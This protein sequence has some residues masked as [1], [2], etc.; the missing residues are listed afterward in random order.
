MSLSQRIAPH[1]LLC[2][3]LVRVL[4]STDHSAIVECVVPEY[5]T[6]LVQRVRTRTPHGALY[7]THSAT[8]NA[9]RIIRYDTIRSTLTPELQRA[10]T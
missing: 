8:E 3:I 1:M 2:G 6:L 5:T 4:H 10:L 9:V 7:S